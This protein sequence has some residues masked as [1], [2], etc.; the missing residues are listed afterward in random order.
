MDEKS[1]TELV[2]RYIAIWNESDDRARRALL[3]DVFTP[4]ATYVDPNTAAEGAPAIDRYIAAAQR[5]FGG[6]SFTFGEVL[7]H[8]DAVHFAWQ[9]G[10]AGGAPVV[11][12]F[13]V[14][15]LDG[16]RIARL[17]GFFTGC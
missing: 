5:N 1:V 16:G 6:M 13:D 10:P 9:V 3:D 14:A 2:G 11:G 4:G 17:Y 12:G 15:W 7:T 8:H